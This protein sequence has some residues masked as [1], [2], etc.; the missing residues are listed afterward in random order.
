M[1]NPVFVPVTGIVRDVSS[2][3]NQCCSQMLTLMTR[4]GIV[5]FLIDSETFVVDNVQLRR[6][7]RITAFYD[8]NLPV[9][10]IYPPRYQAAIITQTAPNQNVMADFFDRNLSAVNH[11]LRLN[12]GPSTQ[13][14]TANGQRFFCRPSGQYLVVFYGPTTR[15]LPPQTTPQRVIV[16]C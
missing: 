15:S 9:P 16:L 7:M 8:Q 6:G 13:I 2:F 1:A 5:N 3:Q 14:T 4:N 11:S 10:L 12:L